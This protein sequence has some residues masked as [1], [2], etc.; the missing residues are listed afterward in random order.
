MLRFFLILVIAVPAFAQ[1]PLAPSSSRIW[2]TPLKLPDET[3][4]VSIEPGSDDE[5]FIYTIRRQFLADTFVEEWTSNHATTQLTFRP[6]GRLISEHHENLFR[7]T[8]VD[9]TVDEKRGSVR[10]IIRENGAVRSDKTAGLNPGIALREEMNHLVLQTWR[11]GIHDKLICQSLSPDGG[12]V[13]DFQIEFHQ[14]TDPTTLSTRY[15]YPAEFRAAFTPAPYIVADMSLTGMASLFFPHH[16]YL[17]YVERGGALE[18]AGY[19]GEDPKKPVF[20]FM[21]KQG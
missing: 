3:D 5:R 6:D 20:Q 16:F 9:V 2:A 19:F 1:T 13:G 4:L 18:W 7:K 17:V 12:L 11:A 21:P 15:T 14:V 8:S 10:T